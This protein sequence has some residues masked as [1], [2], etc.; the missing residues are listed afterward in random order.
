MITCIYSNMEPKDT[1]LLVLTLNWFGF[2]LDIAIKVK[3]DV[4]LPS[5]SFVWHLLD[6]LRR[7]EVGSSGTQM[8]R[9]EAG[10]NWTTS[11]LVEFTP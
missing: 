2:P 10:V 7:K 8:R 11:N 6:V 3:I 4:K 1:E 5:K 9:A